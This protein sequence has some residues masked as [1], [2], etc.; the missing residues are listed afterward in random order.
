MKTQTETTKIWLAAMCGCLVWSAGC[1]TRKP[2][3]K[4]VV[5]FIAVVHPVIPPETAPDLESPPNL[6]GEVPEPPELAL[7][8]AQPARPHVAP[9]PTP[10]P[11][12]E[13]HPEP[14]IAPQVTTEEMIAAKT[15]TQ[16]DLDAAERNLAMAQGK[17]LNATQQDL[18][19]KIRGFADNAKEAMRVGDWVKAKNFS[20]KAEV[21][22]EQLAESL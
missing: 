16:H 7:S 4:P 12:A 20:K 10:E 6:S 17:S 2:Q 13:K 9:A 18:A 1:D 14:T 21:L 22:S 8:K 19:S 3:A 11:A 5:N 15:E